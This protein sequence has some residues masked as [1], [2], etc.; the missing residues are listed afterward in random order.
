MSFVSV[1]DIKFAWTLAF[2]LY[3]KCFTKVE[4][5]GKFRGGRLS[6]LCQLSAIISN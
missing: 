1:S 4:R 3:D 5:A 6:V 2:F